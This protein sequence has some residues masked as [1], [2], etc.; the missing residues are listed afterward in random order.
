MQYKAADAGDYISQIPEERQAAMKKLRA[1]INK[2]ISIKTTAAG[3]D[4]TYAQ[5]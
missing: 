5:N 4:G 1:V 2:K 3:I